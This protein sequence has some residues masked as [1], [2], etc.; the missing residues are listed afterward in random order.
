M[1]IFGL[2]SSV[3]VI[4]FFCLI[5]YATYKFYKWIEE[6][7]IRSEELNEEL[8]P[9]MDKL[10]N[11]KTPEEFIRAREEINDYFKSKIDNTLEGVL[12]IR[13][14]DIDEEKIKADFDKYKT[15]YIDDLLS[16]TVNVKTLKKSVE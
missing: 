2:V 14:S 1:E 15:E 12:T 7:K 5:V 13:L 16:I 10:K 8:T 9:L 11:A 4:V 3:I 6:I